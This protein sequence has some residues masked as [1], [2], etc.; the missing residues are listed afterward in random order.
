M[1]GRAS[2]T[3]Q[4]T[5][6]RSTAWD[7]PDSPQHLLKLNLS[8]PLYRDKLFA[9]LEYQ[10]TSDRRTVFTSTSGATVAGD[11]TAGFGVLNATLFS[12]NLVKN[13]EFSASIYNLLDQSYSDPAS[14]IHAQDKILQDGRSFR[15][16]LT[17]R[18]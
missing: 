13:L 10:Y 15:I 7:F 9:G 2:Y 6:N 1:R 3:F 18:F 4:K 11:D 12:Q 8:G 5:Q 16:K 17:Y 14:R